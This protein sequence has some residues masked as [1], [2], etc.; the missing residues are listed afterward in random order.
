MNTQQQVPPV[1]IRT[2][3]YWIFVIAYLVVI[4]VIPL[5]VTL[6]TGSGKEWLGLT[7]SWGGFATIFAIVHLL[8]SIKTRPVH[9]HLGLEILG[10]PALEKKTPGPLIAPALPGIVTVL[11]M[12]RNVLQNQFPGEPEQIEWRD[13]KEVLAELPDGNLPKNKVWPIRAPTGPAR[14]G[15]RGDGTKWSKDD[16]FN[17][18]MV[19]S[20]TFYVRYCVTNLFQFLQTVGIEGPDAV[21]DRLVQQLRDTGERVLLDEFRKRNVA[22]VITEITEISNAMKAAF[23][24]ITET[25]GVDIVEVGVLMP[26]PGH[27]FNIAV[28]EIGEA[29]ARAQQT[30]ITADASEYNLTREGVGRGNAHEAEIRG[31]IRGLKEAEEVGVDPVVVIAATAAQDIAKNANYAYFGE[32]GGV[33]GIANAIADALK[34]GSKNVPKSQAGGGESS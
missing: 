24:T 25:W 1:V 10:M 17:I 22:L 34:Q 15:D 16:P 9:E 26:S 3:I 2:D 21:F 23:D 31:R 30:R 18:Q 27:K 28:R 33:G 12:T 19:L 4:M 20:V 13:E 6:F 11:S 8:R 7:W 14:E 29:K 32:L 5:T